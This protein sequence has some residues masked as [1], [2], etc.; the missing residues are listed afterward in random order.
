VAALSKTWV[1]GSST[2]GIAGSNTAGGGGCLERVVCF[3]SRS[4]R[5]A[6]HSFGGVLPIVM[7]LRVIVGPKQ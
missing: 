5:Q 6:D 3:R 4:L 7:C 1:C 2:A